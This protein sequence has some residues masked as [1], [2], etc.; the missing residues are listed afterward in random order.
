[1]TNSVA[2]LIATNSNPQQQ[3]Q[4]KLSQRQDILS[5]TSTLMDESDYT[6]L[7]YCIEKDSMV[8]GV[9]YHNLYSKW[10]DCA[11]LDRGQ[12]NYLNFSNN[13]TTGDPGFKS[14][15]NVLSN[16]LSL[17]S[18]QLFANSTLDANYYAHYNIAKAVVA[19]PTQLGQQ[20]I[21]GG[22]YNNNN[23]NNNTTESNGTSRGNSRG[24]DSGTQFS[25][26]QST[27]DTD[28]CA[29]STALPIAKH[30]NVH[31]QSNNVDPKQNR[32]SSQ[33]FQQSMGNHGITLFSEATNFSQQNNNTHTIQPESVQSQPSTSKN[34]PPPP[35]TKPPPTVLPPTVHIQPSSQSSRTFS[36]HV[37]HQGKDPSKPGKKEIKFGPRVEKY[38]IGNGLGF[39]DI[40]DLL[41]KNKA[42][43]NDYTS[44][45]GISALMLCAKYNRKDLCKILLKEP[46]YADINA[47]DNLGRS[48]LGYAKIENNIDL[49][50]WLFTQGAR[51]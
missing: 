31:Y 21:G 40:I 22:T 42:D 37:S 39:R 9:D 1:V 4:S 6:L 7:M 34:P 41:L 15:S 14:P 16:S 36:F 12:Y 23:N 35:S 29:D 24:A 33:Q 17:I 30:N 50:N 32:R 20:L 25:R 28:S 45:G 2:T 43:V 5:K 11:L 8:I 49:A 46:F 13:N 51:L 48:V 47:R 44:N 3:Q 27:V 19:P 26:T 38:N 18:S 10:Y